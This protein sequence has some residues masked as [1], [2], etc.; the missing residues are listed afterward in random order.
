MA[1]S[2]ELV[3]SVRFFE[4]INLPQIIK[5]NISRLRCTPVPYKPERTFNRNRRHRPNNFA[6][7]ASS[8]GDWRIS[9]I[10]N[11]SKIVKDQ[12]DAQYSEIIG[13]V[14]KL[15]P[16]NIEKLSS[17]ALKIMQTKDEDFRLR[18]TTLL[19]DRAITQPTFSK[20][21]AECAF[22]LDTVIP[23][24][25]EDLEAQISVFPT[26]YNM[27]ETLTFPDT[28]DPYDERL[29]QWVKQKDKR[30]GYARFMM[31]LF[32]KEMINESVVKPAL[33]QIIEDLKETVK[34]PKTPLTEENITQFVVFLF[35][36]STEVNGELKQY[37][38]E[39]IKTI[40]DTPKAE[41]PSLTMKS[42]FKLEDAFKELNK[43]ENT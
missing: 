23:E 7:L 43:E 19:F 24:I 10:L 14:N 17:D 26:L 20:I 38:K 22:L 29:V 31:A 27:N 11:F 3:Y 4:K 35:E 8:S 39:T 36:A 2:V 34:Q 15:S 1:L 12:Q 32:T 16:Q 13:I 6:R 33:E 40:L 42:K 25:S 37:L 21:I 41:M 30:R 28:T 9:K 5:D 18:V